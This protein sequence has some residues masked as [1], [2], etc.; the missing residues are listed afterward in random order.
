[1]LMPKSICFLTSM[2]GDRTRCLNPRQSAMSH[3]LSTSSKCVIGT[4]VHLLQPL[5]G[6]RLPALPPNSTRD[7]Q[8]HLRFALL[9]VG[10]SCLRLRRVRGAMDPTSV[11]FRCGETKPRL[12]DGARRC[13]AD[14]EPW[15][16]HPSPTPLFALACALRVSGCARGGF[17]SRRPN[18][19]K[20]H[21]NAAFANVP[22]SWRA[23]R[24]Q[25]TGRESCC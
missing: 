3:V 19:P 6:W 24:E 22:G 17:S 23:W 25:G 5:R 21:P 1:M 7:R 8:T 20:K 4:S 2:H 9:T 18:Q 16:W 12:P 11:H 15:L 10:C 14:R 13:Q